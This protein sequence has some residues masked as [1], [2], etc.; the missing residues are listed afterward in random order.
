MKVELQ[1][2][3]SR[4]KSPH[5]LSVALYQYCSREAGLERIDFICSRPAGAL[6]MT[7]FMEACSQQLA[8]AL[9]GRLGANVY[10]DKC[11]FFEVPLANDFICDIAP[12]DVSRA[13]R[14]PSSCKCSW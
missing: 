7:C 10:G 6:Q 12:F 2:V 4:A 3:L 5:A 1:D 9:A 13:R 14:E 8:Q 11:V